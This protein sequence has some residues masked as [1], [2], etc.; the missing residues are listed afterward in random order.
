MWRCVQRQFD[1][2]LSPE[3]RTWAQNQMDRQTERGAKA[4]E[5]GDQDGLEAEENGEKSQKCDQSIR[6]RQ[7]CRGRRVRRARN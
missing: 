3:T 6:F 5:D 7:L 1:A 4:G 2:G